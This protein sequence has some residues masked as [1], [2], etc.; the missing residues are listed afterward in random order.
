MKYKDPQ[1]FLADLHRIKKNDCV[2]EALEYLIK[3][4]DRDIDL[5]ER[6]NL[7]YRAVIRAAKKLADAGAW[8]EVKSLLEDEDV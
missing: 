1:A 5:L 7:H 4:V 6:D 8:D 2:I 3:E